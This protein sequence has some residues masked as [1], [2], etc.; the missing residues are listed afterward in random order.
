MKESDTP[1]TNVIT[2][3]LQNNILGD[4]KNTN[5]KVSATLVTNVD[6]RQQ[7]QVIFKHM[8]IHKG[9]L[10]MAIVIKKLFQVV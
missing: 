10:I 7:Q 3:L 6:I 9:V 8:S 2:E 1:A 4:I 5:M